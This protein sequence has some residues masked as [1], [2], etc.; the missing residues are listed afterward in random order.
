VCETGLSDMGEP[1]GSGAARPVRGR[2]LPVMMAYNTGFRYTHVCF[3]NFPSG[4]HESRGLLKSRVNF[5]HLPIDAGGS[6]LLGWRCVT[7]M[8]CMRPA[9]SHMRDT[10]RR[11]QVQDSEVCHQ[12]GMHEASME[13]HA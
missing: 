5:K 10:Y 12:N 6:G 3:E 8:A 2:M 9:W 13:P 4:V 11:T 7:K 1:P